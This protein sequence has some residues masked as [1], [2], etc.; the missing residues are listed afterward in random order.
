MSNFR[1]MITDVIARMLRIEDV[2]GPTWYARQTG[3]TDSGTARRPQHSGT[4][5]GTRSTSLRPHESRDTQ[6]TTPSA[7][8]QLLAD[9]QRKTTDLLI[10]VQHVL[11]IKRDAFY[12]ARRSLTDKTVDLHHRVERCSG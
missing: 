12:G 5:A 3:R 1:R 6:P 4:D 9:V 7:T 2:R 10:E 11:D 8:P